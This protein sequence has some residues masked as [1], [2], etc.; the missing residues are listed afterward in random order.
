MHK[1]VIVLQLG[2]PSGLYGAERWILA[3]IKHLDS[4]KIESYVASIKDDADYKVPLCIEAEKIGFTSNIIESFGKINVSAIKK[5]RNYIQDNNIDILHTHGY[6]TDILGLL[7]TKGTSCKIV[8][9]PHGWT[10]QPDLKLWCYE[11]LDRCLYPFFDA[12]VPLSEEMFQPLRR[13]PGMKNKINLIRNAVDI[14][15]V[16]NEDVIASDIAAYK[17]E[18]E[19]VIGYIGRLIPD[20]GLDILFEAVAR[21]G[22]SNWRIAIVGEGEY[23]EALKLLANNLNIINQV[24]FFG[25]R[26]DR[27]SLLKGFDVFVLPS[28]SEGTPRC[29]MESMAAGVPVVV[30]DIPGCRCLVDGET[31]GLLFEPDQSEQLAK[32]ITRILSDASLWNMF[33]TNGR[34]FI[35]SKFSAARMAKE[36]TDLF[37]SLTGKSRS[38]LVE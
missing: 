3:L 36:Y 30:T 22:Q 38:N 12:V 16:E 8:S 35:K 21:Y 19:V 28:R 2:D 20:K 5:L 1:K 6:K 27:L 10:K 14:S 26:H 34:K 33:S 15:E 4:E 13:I 11:V 18:G 32:A 9:T 23:M 7:A 25:F 31:T 29:V 37:I 24:S 17:N